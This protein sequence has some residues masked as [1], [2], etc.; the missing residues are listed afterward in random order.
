M[1]RCRAEIGPFPRRERPGP[2][3]P[4][5]SSVYPRAAATTGL[6][7][8]GSGRSRLIP[9]RIW[10]WPSATPGSPGQRGAALGLLVC[11]RLG[12]REGA[13]LDADRMW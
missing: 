4:P 2:V 6:P 8:A 3:H 5:P 13:E 1:R 9:T 11:A 12:K 10:P 7:L